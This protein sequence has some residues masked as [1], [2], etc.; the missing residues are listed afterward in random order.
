MNFKF[1]LNFSINLEFL[2]F[3]FYTLPQKKAYFIKSEIFLFDPSFPVIYFTATLAKKNNF[4]FKF[5]L[6]KYMHIT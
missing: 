5:I 6:F 3:F 1:I 2:I 4:F